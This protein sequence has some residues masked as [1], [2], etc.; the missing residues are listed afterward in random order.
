MVIT[1]KNLIGLRVFTQMG[2]ELGKICGFEIDTDTRKIV[3]YYV[4]KHSILTELLDG[5]DF[6]VSDGLVVSVSAEKMVV[7]DTIIGDRNQLI[8]LK[9]KAESS[10]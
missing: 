8:E 1:S 10:S 7:E 3:N 4:K 6:V 5:K 9:R 2:Q